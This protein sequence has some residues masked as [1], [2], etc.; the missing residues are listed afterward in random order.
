VA[1]A[2]NDRTSKRI[3]AVEVEVD[4]PRQVTT[5]AGRCGE[6]PRHGYGPRELVLSDA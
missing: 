5:I 3:R 4:Q 6:V 1:A 2:L